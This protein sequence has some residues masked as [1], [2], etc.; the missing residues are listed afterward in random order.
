MA[1]Q[2][3]ILPTSLFAGESIVKTIT[4]VTV[5]GYTLDYKFN[6]QPTPISVTCTGATTWTLTVTSVQ[7]LLWQRGVVSFV[8]YLTNTSDGSVSVV[9]F[10]DIDVEASPMATSQYTAALAAVEAA[11]LTYASNPNRKINVGSINIEYKDMNELLKLR[12]FYQSEIAKQTGR[13]YGG[14]VVTLSTRF[15]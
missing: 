7:T 12:A 11:I 13:G 10:G 5:T 14:G 3:S 6:C 2:K 9:D 4:G 1:E 15:R 8:A